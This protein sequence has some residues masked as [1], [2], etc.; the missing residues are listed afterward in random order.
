ME[1]EETLSPQQSLELISSV[2]AKT[3]DN[4]K[5]NS[6]LFIL[7]GWLIST[8]SILFFV[9]N[10]F[11]NFK[12]FFL[13]FPVLAL[14][15]ISISLR[16]YIKQKRRTT[17]T[18]LSYF[19]YRMWLVLGICFITVVFINVSQNLIPVTYTLLVAGIGTLV[20][21]LVLKFN[22]LIFGGTLFLIS[23]VL[24]IYIPI[25]YRMLFHG[26]I[27]IAGYLIPG[28]LLKYSKP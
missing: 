16:Y 18:H 26:V 24:S 27:I 11:T 5:A 9:L 19:L 3:K 12:Y 6:F 7:W 4:I 14:L 22:P 17:E 1:T 25:E 13:P 23:A 20:S 2:I 15:G 10:R 21:G 28:Y 8:A